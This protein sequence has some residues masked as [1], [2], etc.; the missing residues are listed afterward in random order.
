MHLSFEAYCAC[1]VVMLVVSGFALGLRL[2]TRFAITN[3]RGTD[4]HLLLAAWIA[5]IVDTTAQLL[6][7]GANSLPTLA[8]IHVRS[9]IL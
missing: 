1:Y 9:Y 6:Y 5:I 4:D 8:K 2:Y 3:T 7:S